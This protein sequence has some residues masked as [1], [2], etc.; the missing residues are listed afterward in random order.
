MATGVA[1]HP[2]AEL[3]QRGGWSMIDTKSDVAAWIAESHELAKS[4][5]YSPEILAAVGRPGELKPINLPESYLKAAGDH[6]RTRIIA[7][8]LRLANLIELGD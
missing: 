2:V 5:A 4:F 1:L 8:G 6:A 7:V 3:K